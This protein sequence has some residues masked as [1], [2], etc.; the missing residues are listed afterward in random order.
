MRLNGRGNNEVAS[1][2]ERLISRASYDFERSTE[3]QRSGEAIK[4]I[5]GKSIV[6]ARVTGR[7]IELVTDDGYRLAFYGLIEVVAPGGTSVYD[8]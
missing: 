1:Q 8:G 3:L 5:D 7:H 4:T 6:S 2:V